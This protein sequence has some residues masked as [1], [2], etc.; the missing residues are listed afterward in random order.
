MGEKL[1]DVLAALDAAVNTLGEL[2]RERDWVAA[3][4]ASRAVLSSGSKLH[5]RLTV[6]VDLGDEATWFAAVDKAVARGQAAEVAGQASIDD[7]L[8]AAG[9]KEAKDAAQR[10]AAA[11]RKRKPKA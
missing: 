6:M 3:R 11:A 2:L 9:A 4:E 1:V 10:D 5:A 7:V 8:R